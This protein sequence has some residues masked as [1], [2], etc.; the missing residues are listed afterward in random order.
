M[1][2]RANVSYGIGFKIDLLME[3]EIFVLFCLTYSNGNEATKNL[4]VRKNHKGIP[5]ITGSRDVVLSKMFAQ[6]DQQT[7]FFPPAATV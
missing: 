6:L 7:V 3:I 2:V 4:E 1:I 5:L